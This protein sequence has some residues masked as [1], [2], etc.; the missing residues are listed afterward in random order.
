MYHC[1]ACASPIIN[2]LACSACALA[3]QASGKTT[4]P[5]LHCNFCGKQQDQRGTECKACEVARLVRLHGAQAAR[6]R[7]RTED[8]QQ[9][10]LW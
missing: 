8:V 4:L 3:A 6:P 1:V 2:G 5:V 7:R 9:A 10:T